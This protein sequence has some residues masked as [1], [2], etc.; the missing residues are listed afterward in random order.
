MY[1]EMACRIILSIIL[2][3]SEVENDHTAV[4]WVLL[5]SLKNLHS[6]GLQELTVLPYLCAY[7]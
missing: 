4:P 6:S 1:L 2:V 5:A 3:V 7:V